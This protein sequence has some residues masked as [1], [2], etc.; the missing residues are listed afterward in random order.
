MIY[1]GMDAFQH[2]L[3]QWRRGGGR[4]G[5]GGAVQLELPVRGGGESAQAAD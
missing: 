1:T 2:R 3:G 5:D 4:G